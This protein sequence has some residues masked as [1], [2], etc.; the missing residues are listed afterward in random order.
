MKKSSLITVALASLVALVGCNKQS[1]PKPAK[2]SESFKMCEFIAGALLGDEAVKYV[3]TM[4]ELNPQW[5]DETAVSQSGLYL[6]WQYDEEFTAEDL[7]DSDLFEAFFLGTEETEEEPAQA[8]LW[9]AVEEKYAPDLVTT[10]EPGYYSSAGVYG[11][12]WA[13]Y[14]LDGKVI[15]ID[16]QFANFTVDV[17]DEEGE[18]TGETISGIYLLLRAE[19][20]ELTLDYLAAIDLAKFIFGDAGLSLVMNMADL[21]P[22]WVNEDAVHDSAIFVTTQSGAASAMFAQL[23]TAPEP[24]EGEE[25]QPSLFEQY[26]DEYFT[27]Y[28]EDFSTPYAEGATYCDYVDNLSE[29]L[30]IEYYFQVIAGMYIVC[31]VT[32]WDWTLIQ[33]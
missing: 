20:F 24:E 21:L 30:S 29:D 16:L 4:E 27:E 31:E 12:D 28:D 9:D 6:E 7:E 1:G 18:P 2:K 26:M 8:P 25:A 22:G 23:F 11:G 13:Y 19:E 3:E 17:E 14:G 5:V 33:A 32:L 10:A 15:N